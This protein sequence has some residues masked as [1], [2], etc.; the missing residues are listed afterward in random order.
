MLPET[1]AHLR[2]DLRNKRLAAGIRQ[3]L[4]PKWFLRYEY[5][6]AD[7]RGEAGLLY[8]MHDFLGLEL[9]R[10]TKDNWL[11]VIGNF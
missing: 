11:R 6:W 9:I 5:R 10:D 7:Q 3:K 2:Y 4:A 1:D 8:Q